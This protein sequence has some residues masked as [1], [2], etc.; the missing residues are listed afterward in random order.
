MADGTEIIAI[1]PEILHKVASEVTAVG[2]RV[3]EVDARIRSNPIAPGAFGLMNAWMAPPISAL[4]SHTAEVVQVTAQLATAVGAATAA[5]AD[6]FERNEQTI[7]SGLG[8][9]GQQLDGTPGTPGTPAGLSGPDGLDAT[10]GRAI[11][12]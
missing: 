5:S 11:L 7:V 8:S 12:R 3:G 6:D 4:I 2:E 1:D 9:L 10:S